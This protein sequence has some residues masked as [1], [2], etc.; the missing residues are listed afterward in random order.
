MSTVRES[1]AGRPGAR[2]PEPGPESDAKDELKSL[3]V[4]E[5]GKRLGSSPDGLSQDEAT[6]RLARYGP[7]EIEEKKENPLLKL[8]AYFWDPIPWMIEAAV[9][10]SGVLRHWP[11][12][13]IILPPAPPRTRPW[14]WPPAAAR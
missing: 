5:G 10:L 12:F 11:D 4:P 7:N 13:F 2:G 9:I 1:G 6:E 3:P 8:L 14:H